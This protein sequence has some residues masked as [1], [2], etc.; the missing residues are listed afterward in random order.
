MN[1]RSL[2][3]NSDFSTQVKNNMSTLY[4]AL[5]KKTFERSEVIALLN[6]SPLTATNYLKKM[7]EIGLLEPVKGQGKSQFRFRPGEGER[8]G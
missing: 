4:A 1:I 7:N 6:C 3:D 2:I 5:V 8:I